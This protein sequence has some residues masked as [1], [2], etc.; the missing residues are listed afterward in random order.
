M[1]IREQ[2]YNKYNQ[3]CAYSGTDLESDWQ[4]DHVVPHRGNKRLRDDNIKNLM[5]VQKIINHYKRAL[6]LED[7]R[8]WY[9]GGLHKRLA[10]LPQN[11]RSERGIKRKKYLLRV[12]SYFEITPDKPFCGKFYFETLKPQNT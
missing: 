8:G 6:K 10:K 3:K 1:N 9:L 11:P 2:V 12:A 5:P 7:F 4:I